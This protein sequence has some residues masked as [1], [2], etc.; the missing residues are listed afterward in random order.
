M[1]T[2]PPSDG[3]DNILF[4]APIFFDEI[5]ELTEGFFVMASFSF[6]D[7]IDEANFSP[8]IERDTALI[9]IVNDDSKY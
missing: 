1:M 5:H 3:V 8:N 7:P 4:E 9:R 2:I 6:V